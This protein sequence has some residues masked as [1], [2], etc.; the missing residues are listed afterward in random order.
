MRGLSR[1]PYP[2][3]VTTAEQLAQLPD[4]ECRYELVEGRLR[5]MSPVGGVHGMLVLRLGAAIAA[6]VTERDLGVVMTETGFVLGRHPDT[7]RAPDLAFVCASR[8]PRAGVPADYWPGAP[9]LVA[10]VLSPG[11]RRIEMR[12]KVQDY[13]RSGVR[14]VWVIDPAARVCTVYRTLSAIPRRV[15][16]TLDGEDVLPGFTCSLSHLFA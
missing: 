7:V 16:H 12:A 2:A 15:A 10:E 8:I 5:R 13:L 4:D 9:D 6:W 11:D 3:S 1:V 14:L